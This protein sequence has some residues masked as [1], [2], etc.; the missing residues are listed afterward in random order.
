[1]ANNIKEKE[2][3]QK[4]RQLE[5]DIKE[6]KRDH[7]ETFVTMKY[8]TLDFVMPSRKQLIC[9]A[10]GTML[11]LIAGLL[12]WFNA[13]VFGRFALF[14]IK[15]LRFT[16][17]VFFLPLIISALL[18]VICKR[19][20]AVFISF[21]PESVLAV[22]GIIISVQADKSSFPIWLYAILYSVLFIGAGL[23]AGSVYAYYIYKSSS[24]E[25]FKESL[26]NEKEKN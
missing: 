10:V 11:I 21:I 6:M 8:P 12:L 25:K 7:R 16:R 2:K 20:K 13:P 3:K 14:R 23:V 1:M 15:N 22:I 5:A 18:S 24:A 17:T 4:I 9:G 26:T 19:K